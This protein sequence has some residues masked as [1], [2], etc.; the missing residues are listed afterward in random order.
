[1]SMSTHICSYSKCQLTASERCSRCRSYYYCSRDHQLLDWNSHK[2]TCTEISLSAVTKR[3]KTEP[4][5]TKESQQN[6]KTESSN[7]S[8]DEMRECRCMFCGK[9]LLLKSEE[10]A[11][12]HMRECID[13]QEQLTSKNDFEIPSSIKSKVLP[14]TINDLSNS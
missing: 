10:E 14:A 8:S 4:C 11:C 5:M 6:D 7:L 12:Q 3:E 13:L 1:M 2:R 9:M